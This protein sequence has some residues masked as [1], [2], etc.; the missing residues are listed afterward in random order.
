MPNAPCAAI[1]YYW[2]ATTHGLQRGQSAWIVTLHTQ[3][4][5]PQLVSRGA[6]SVFAIRAG[7]IYEEVLPV[8]A[9]VRH[10][11]QWRVQERI[12]V[13]FKQPSAEGLRNRMPPTLCPTSTPGLDGALIRTLRATGAVS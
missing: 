11:N 8:T 1:P 2:Q 13:R 7:V 6:L 3:H 12:S 10:L 4:L 9:G 5:A